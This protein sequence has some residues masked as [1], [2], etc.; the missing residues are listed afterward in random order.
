MREDVLPY[1]SERDARGEIADIFADIRD[2]LRVP[3]VN[4]IWRHFATLD[5]GLLAAW[6]ALRPIYASGA[7]E[8]AGAR[9]LS[10]LALPSYG[11]KSATAAPR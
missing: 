4:L 10:G 5:G 1:V 11:S 8:A 9:L 2:T 3:V 7:A 6:E